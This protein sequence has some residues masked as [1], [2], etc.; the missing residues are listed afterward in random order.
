MVRSWRSNRRSPPPRKARARTVRFAH[1]LLA[2][3][4]TQSSG[5]GL[6]R[7]GPTGVSGLPDWTDQTIGPCTVVR[8]RTWW[9]WRLYDDANPN[10]E[11]RT[12]RRP[13]LLSALAGR[14]PGGPSRAGS[15]R[16]EHPLLRPPG[17]AARNRPSPSRPG[18]RTP[19]R[20]RGA[21]PPPRPG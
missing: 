4:T 3:L 10:L 21:R 15:A 20:D 17:G 5:L 14:H 9:V 6:R 1:R 2:P 16:G 13:A 19:E 7:L 11:R 8:R 18:K 12:P